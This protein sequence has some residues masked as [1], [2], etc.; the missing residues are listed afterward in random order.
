MDSLKEQKVCKAANEL[1]SKPKYIHQCTQITINGK[2]L[3]G[4]IV[5][6]NKDGYFVRRNDSFLYISKDGRNCLSSKFALRSSV[7]DFGKLSF[8][9]EEIDA[10]CGVIKPSSI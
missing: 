4:Y 9:D 8:D 6:E 5:L 7:K 1:K 2:M 10:F 3:M